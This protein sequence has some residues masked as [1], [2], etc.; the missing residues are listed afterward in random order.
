[1]SDN[2]PGGQRVPRTEHRATRKA[3]TAAAIGNAAPVLLLVAE[4]LVQST[5][6]LYSPAWLVMAA[7]AVGVLVVWRMRE[8][9][10]KPLPGAPAIPVPE[11]AP[12]AVGS[13]PHP[14]RGDGSG[15]SIRGS[16]VHRLPSDP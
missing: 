1:M 9:A 8:S 10:G 6:N 13:L 16:N 7:G 4:S 2:Q 5:G 12:A 3:V 11:R 15:R 14:R